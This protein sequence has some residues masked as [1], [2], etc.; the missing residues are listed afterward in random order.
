MGMAMSV[1]WPVGQSRLKYLNNYLMD[2]HEILYK[3]SWL[4]EDEPL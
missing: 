3:H 2:C 4:P 1:C